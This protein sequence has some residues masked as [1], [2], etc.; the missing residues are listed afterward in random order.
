MALVL[1]IIGNGKAVHIADFF[2][3]GQAQTQRLGLI[4]VLA[5]TV[6]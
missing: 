2:Y 3:N 4:G 5:E 1:V 6:E